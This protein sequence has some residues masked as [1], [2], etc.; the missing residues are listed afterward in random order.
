MKNKKSVLLGLTGGKKSIVAA[1]LLLKQGY[2]V[3]GCSLLMGDLGSTCT[4]SEVGK[5]QEI[6][7]KLGIIHTTID[8][9]S[10]YKEKIILPLIGARLSGEDSNPCFYCNILKFESLLKKAN[11]K[12]IDFI[13]S[14]HMANLM[15]D[16]S[17]LKLY[18]GKQEEYDQSFFLSGL[19][20]NLLERL[21][22]PLGK[23]SKDE[24]DKIALSFGE[25]FGEVKNPKELCIRDLRSII[26][27]IEK[28]VPPS[29]RM[30]GLIINEETG[31]PLGPH[32]GIYNFKL[33]ILDQDIYSNFSVV[34]FDTYKKN[35]LVRENFR[36]IQDR[37]E[38]IM[39]SS[40]LD[41]DLSGPLHCTFALGPKEQKLACTVFLGNNGHAVVK[42]EKP[43]EGP[44]EKGR[45][46]VFYDPIDGSSR[47]I[48][49]A[50]VSNVG[51]FINNQKEEGYYIN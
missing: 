29:L 39:F 11:D 8:L 43:I 18:Q 20:E 45:L 1:Y 19:R 5:A 4:L 22:L 33:G 15:D 35:V 34:G 37:V 27:V 6:C 32:N 2:E 44:I 3:I 50:F 42:L 25:E 23:L 24:I 41:I 49:T 40:F 14:G 51:Q 12:N 26:P 21:I 28:Q 48:A 47:L 31:I 7:K 10:E 17:G 16:P 46:V 36:F 38:V 13:A 30:A 9:R